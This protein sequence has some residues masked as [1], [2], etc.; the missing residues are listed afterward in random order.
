MYKL[1]RTYYNI[2]L[3]QFS[4][5]QKKRSNYLSSV[6]VG[7]LPK[8]VRSTKT[9]C[10]PETII[11]TSTPRRQLKHFIIHF[12]FIYWLLSLLKSKLF[13]YFRSGHFISFISVLADPDL[14]ADELNPLTKSHIGNNSSNKA[15][16]INTITSPSISIWPNIYNKVPGNNNAYPMRPKTDKNRGMSFDLYNKYLDFTPIL[17]TTKKH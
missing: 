16:G 15:P 4:F 7:G 9:H 13:L 17:Y 14:I 5:L 3:L 8:N 6:A 12:H 11:K 1:L 2:V 10:N